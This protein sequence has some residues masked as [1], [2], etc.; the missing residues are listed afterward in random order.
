MGQ[1]TKRKGL[2]PD[3]MAKIEALEASIET[4]E[5]TRV[6][7]LAAGLLNVKAQVDHLAVLVSISSHLLSIARI[8]GDLHGV[9]ALTGAIAKL[10]D[11]MRGL[12]KLAIDDK[13][14]ELLKRANQQSE[15]KRILGAA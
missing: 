11:D 3:K 2:D 5:A 15:A 9:V 6:K 1:T 8:R 4:L 7:L 10:N 13:L 12:V 14:D